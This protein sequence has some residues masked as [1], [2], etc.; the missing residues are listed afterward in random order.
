[1]EGCG[2]G[3]FGKKRYFN[4]ADGKGHFCRICDIQSLDSLCSPTPPATGEAPPP[5]VPVS[6][7]GGG[8]SYSNRKY[9][10]LGGKR[11]HY[12]TSL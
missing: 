8:A 12:L 11:C 2:D 4:C 9:S 3:G 6:T 1:M 7:S 10:V 5:T